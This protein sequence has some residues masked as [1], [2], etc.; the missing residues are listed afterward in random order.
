MVSY[1][2]QYDREMLKV[3]SEIVEL[4]KPE[5]RKHRIFQVVLGIGAGILYLCAASLLYYDGVSA[6][7]ILY[8]VFATIFVLLAV[9]DKRLRVFVVRQNLLRTSKQLLSS[10]GTWTFRDD[11]IETDSNLGKGVSY[12][13]AITRYGDYDKYLYIQ[14][15]DNAIYL[16]DRTRLSEAELE[17]LRGLLGRHVTVKA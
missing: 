3:L 12:W 6:N 5:V 10:S 16:L 4:R 17:E 15:E 11:A 14:R 13:S 7:S 8:L 2:F 9:F 1:K